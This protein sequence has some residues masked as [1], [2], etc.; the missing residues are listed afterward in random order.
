M[1]Y[2]MFYHAMSN[3]KIR[4][5]KCRAGEEKAITISKFEYM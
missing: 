2:P 1:F 5:V 4:N 3:F